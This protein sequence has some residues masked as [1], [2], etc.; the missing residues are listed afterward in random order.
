MIVPDLVWIAVAKTHPLDFEPGS[1]HHYSNVNYQL[2]AMALEAATGKDFAS[3]L[4]ER[5]A[6]PSACR[7]LPLHL[8]ILTWPTCTASR[9]DSEARY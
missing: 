1:G 5:P 6:V 7:R 8:P 2:G 3:L 4:H 9:S